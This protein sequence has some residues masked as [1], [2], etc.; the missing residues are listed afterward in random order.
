MFTCIRVATNDSR[1]TIL[2]RQVRSVVLYRDVTVQQCHGLRVILSLVKRDVCCR[3][4]GE[5]AC[6][7]ACD[8]A[9]AEPT[10]T[11]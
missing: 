2:A 10:H 3:L 11:G 8:F 6:M 4:Q 7:E 9:R 5:L 1:S